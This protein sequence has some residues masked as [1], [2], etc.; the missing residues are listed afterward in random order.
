M[1]RSAGLTL[2]LLF[3]AAVALVSREPQADP[4]MRHAF[5]RPTENGW[6]YV[7]LEGA[8]SEVG[9]QHG[10]LLAPEIRDAQRV[11][12]LELTQD[13]K[14]S[15]KFFRDAAKSEL[16]PH[17]EPQYRE[18]LAGIA[19]GLHARGARLD[20]W[21]VVAL[22]AFL[23]WN[24]YYIQWYE[25]K[26]KLPHLAKLTAPEHCSAFVATGSYTK[27]G[28]VVIG[29]NAWTGYLDGERWT[30]VFDIAPSSGHRILM[31]G[32]P[33]LIH[34]ADDFGV[35]AAGIMITETTITRFHGW[36]PDGIPE[37]VRA[38]K[39]MQYASSI[40][41]FARW[42]TEGNNGGYANNWLVADR[43]TNE[44]AS[45][46]LGLKNV[47]LRRTKDGYFAG[48]NFPVNE[49]LTAEE[50]EFDT[51]DMGASANARRVRWEQL[52]EQNK[53]RIDVAAGQ[54]FLADHYD[55]FSKKE[56]PDERTLCGHI[57][58]SPRGSEPW[59]PPHGIAGAVQNKVADAAMAEKMSFTAAAGHACGLQFRAAPHLKAHPEF[60]WQKELLHDMESSPWTTFRA[61]N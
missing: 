54:R 26:N 57:D 61:S 9:Y 16:W 33:G 45:L 53:G 51:K 2:V 35:N 30:M 18:E 44:V 41:E 14:R 38:R 47:T 22:N 40:D 42:M 48:S 43:K 21:D 19:A 27:D 32:F 55:T 8:P 12:A 31:D 10:Y 3:G 58:L 5:R 20:V 17:I 39:A 59:Q 49:K 24:P 7:H 4:R 37:F 6:T 52:M 60:A 29:H 34:S 11:I 25:K 13:T 15:W 56:D 23:E 28:R 46:E 1:R 36:N 50:T